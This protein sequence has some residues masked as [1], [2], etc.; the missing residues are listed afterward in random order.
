MVGAICGSEIAMIE[1]KLIF[2]MTRINTV[3]ILDFSLR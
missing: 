3:L 2:Q 1:K